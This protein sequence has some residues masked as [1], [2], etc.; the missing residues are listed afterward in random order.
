L[1]WQFVIRK[2]TFEGVKPM[3]ELAS[4]PDVWYHVRGYQMQPGGFMTC[5][6][7]P[8]KRVNF[9]IYEGTDTNCDTV[10]G[11][12][13]KVFSGCLKEMF[14][15][16]DNFVME[17]PPNALPVQKAA[18]MTTLILTDFMLFENNQRHTKKSLNIQ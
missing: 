15:D 10:V 13:A 1:Y 11:S 14:T 17:F 5:P 4:L 8:C 18:L 3:P 6:S 9:E 16:A 7:G 12:A 2:P